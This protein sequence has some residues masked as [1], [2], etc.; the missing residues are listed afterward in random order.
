MT[1]PQPIL[2]TTYISSISYTVT[3]H[4]THPHPTLAASAAGREVGDPSPHTSR[5]HTRTSRTHTRTS[6]THTPASSRV[7][8]TPH[9]D[10][11]H[12]RPH[13]R[14]NF[15]NEPTSSTPKTKPALRAGCHYR[16]P[17]HNAGPALESGVMPHCVTTHYGTTHRVTTHRDTTR[18]VTTHCDT[19]S[20]NRSSIVSRRIITCEPSWLTATTAGRSAWL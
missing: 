12:A 8:Q 17:P 14:A 4:F 6:R 11:T 18:R 10:R 1:P 9:P 7:P 15:T 19:S 16:Q 13:Q 2:H 3:L 20:P 5:T